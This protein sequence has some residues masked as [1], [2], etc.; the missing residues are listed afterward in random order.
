MTETDKPAWPTLADGSTDWEA[1][2]EDPQSGLI[3]LITQAQ[4]APALRECAIVVVRQ[5]HTRKKDPDVVAGFVAQLEEM[6]P[7]NLPAGALPK[8]A[9]AIAGVLRQIKEDRIRRA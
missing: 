2:F 6:V 7:D 4:T 9:G 5:L 3:P 1:V 8:V